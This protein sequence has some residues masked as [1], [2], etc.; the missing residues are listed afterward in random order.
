MNQGKNIL[1]RFQNKWQ[2][3]LWLEV[4]LYA[5]GAAVLAA[6]IFRNFLVGVGV[7]ILVGTIFSALLKPWAISLEKVSSFLDRKLPE[8]ENSSQLLL[9]PD[10]N[11]STVAQLQQKKVAG[12]LEEKIK[13]LKPENNLLRAGVIAGSLILIGLLVF[14]FGW[15]DYP[16]SGKTEIEKSE[17]IVLRPADSA[18]TLNK[19]PVV[20]DQKVTV[21]FPAYTS[22]AP[23]TTSK[24]DIEAVKGSRVTWEISFDAKIDSSVM[25]SMGNTYPM[26]FSTGR[27]VRSSNLNSSGFY[28]FRFTD[29]TGAS[30]VSNL[31][32]IT[33]TRDR[34]PEIE[35]PDLPQF[36]SFDFDDE[37]LISFTALITDDFGIDDAYII[38]TVS[39]G[40]GES[41]KFREERLSF[42]S[43]A[44][45][46][47]KKLELNKRINL[48]QMKMEPGDELYFYI[49]AL[50]LKQP[51]ANRSRS[52]TYFA[53]IQDTVSYG[54]GVEGT[55]GVD[56]MPDYFRSQRQLIIDT[57]KLIAGR[58]KI[59]QKEFNTNS[60]DLGF[61]QKALRLRYG[62]FMGD[63]SEGG[64]VTSEAIENSEEE[65]NEDPLAAFTHDHDGNNEHNLVA[66]DQDDHQDHEEDENESPLDKF[67]HDHGDPESATLFTDNLRSKLRQALD[68][69]W[70][71][72]LHLRLHEPE[73]SLPFQYKALA[74]IQEIKNSAR[75]YV[76]RIGYD[77][78]PI[79][80]EVRLTGKIDEVSNYQK[81]AE[82]KIP[83]TEPYIRQAIQ[84]LEKLISENTTITQED[85][86]LF[87]FAGNEL[88]QKAIE[89]PGKYLQTLQHL[90]WLSEERPVSQEELLKVQRGLNM[91]VSKP[92]A[93]PGKG[94][95]FPG[96]MN[97]MVKKELEK[98]GQ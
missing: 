7:F 37:K 96:A 10:E 48:D 75:I 64:V 53:V 3:L 49:E 60:N 20:E 86:K 44:K 78:P 38:A 67:L 97:K 80:E 34:S 76:H 17:T 52:E 87:G 92:V 9:I 88:A 41:V 72:E 25:E 94:R 95:I 5:F 32:S 56:L 35:I 15:L 57:E 39:K 28:N 70:D 13:P 65:E 51:R 55:L 85:R 77:P 61:D 14:S 63:E 68:I 36:T 29:T 26:N 12:R 59:P 42:D 74:L 21:R 82:L 23:Y 31:Y 16:G 93:S 47:N 71:A 4:V 2:L 90:K 81:T 27:Y 54:E 84:R 46:G 1:Q 19:P 45:R 18:A 98:N 79:K 89:T 11:L 6:L 22:V 73:K 83:D 62:Q 33:V 40:T 50:D 91:A 8:I 43:G 30:F 58:N 66:K 24:M 69:M